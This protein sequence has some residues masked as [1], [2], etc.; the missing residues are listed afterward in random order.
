MNLYGVCRF[1]GRYL[2][3]FSLILLIPLAVAILY[4]FFLK[5]ELPYSS[6]TEAFA[7]TL[8]VS[9][10]LAGLFYYLGKKGSSTL[11]RRES[12]LLAGSIWFLTAA[13]AALPFLFS[14][15][16]TNPID[17]YFEAISGLTT[18]GATVMCP[19]AYDE[20]GRHEIPLM[21]KNGEAG[22]Y[23]Y[24]GTIAPLRDAQ[25]QAI[26]ATGVEAIAK[27][28]LFW[29][30]F[31]QWLGGM[32]IILLFI[33]VLPALAM[34]G[35]FLF[36]S[37]MTGPNKETLKPRIRETASMLW[38]IYFGL[39]CIQLILLLATN[40]AV[41]FF[42]ALALALS[43]ISTGGFCVKN[44]GISAYN[45]AATQ[46]II[47]IF[48][49]F[50]SIN[51]TL[52]FHCIKG[53]IYRLYEPE[54]FVFLAT[55]LFSGFLL[56]ITL[57]KTLP[58]SVA[59]RFGFFHAISAQTSTGFSVANE[60]VWP[61]SS[62]FILLMLVFVGGMSGSTCGGMKIARLYILYQ[63]IAHKIETIF[64]PDSVRCL[65]L[66]KKEITDKSALTVLIFICILILLTAV[67]VFFLILDGIDGTT[68]LGVIASMINNA[69]LS[70]G[71]MGENQFYAFL[72]TL[73]KIISILWMVLGRLEFFIL[74]VL[75]VPAFWRSR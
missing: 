18:T 63:V 27:P 45:S 28:L 70:M 12:I 10:I 67:G 11:H 69:G 55:L 39:T 71:A 53:K 50:G 75:L 6:S 32:G 44:A 35:R 31:L 33:A 43:T 42:D 9:L 24:Y 30:C 20:S 47:M 17:A 73:S 41:P 38:K 68:A 51:F 26:L 8:L 16:L 66:G 72:P 4:D 64:R 40:S 52:Y 49:I 3:Y 48:M 29:R 60:Q 7:G 58:V 14:R 15:T 21:I 54:F 34:G 13:V 5:E 37:E 65:R 1:L 62:L 22:H 46:W 19:K 59:L 2:F 74:L 61:F 56:F 57:L 36:E 25:S 23:Q